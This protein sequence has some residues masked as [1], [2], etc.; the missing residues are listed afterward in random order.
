MG[1][2]L[3]EIIAQRTLSP[4]LLGKIYSAMATDS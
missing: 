4:L 1:W 3:E 2:R